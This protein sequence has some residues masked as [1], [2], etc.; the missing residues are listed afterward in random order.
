MTPIGLSGPTRP[1]GAPCDW[2]PA[3]DGTCG[4][5][6]VRDG[7][8]GIYRT[9]TSAWQPSAEDLRCLN[10]GLPLLLTV[11]GSVHPVVALRVGQPSDLPQTDGE[12]A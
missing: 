3:R 12:P 6:I 4:V 2:D 10:L 1:I 5:L 8:E 11:F 9:M 7:V